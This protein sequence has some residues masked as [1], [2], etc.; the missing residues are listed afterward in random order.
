MSLPLTQACS[1]LVRERD[2]QLVA[3]P[4]TSIE[5]LLKV[6]DGALCFDELGLQDLDGVVARRAWRRHRDSEQ[7][8]QIS[9][10]ERPTARV[11]PVEAL[12]KLREQR[13][14]L[15][16]KHVGG[17]RSE[18]GGG[19]ARGSAILF[20]MAIAERAVGVALLALAVFAVIVHV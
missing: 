2:P 7:T 11:A 4:A 5:E 18:L 9:N 10:D 1:T 12:T 8:L 19:P 20:A 16:A 15:P 13:D 3:D 6:I 17:F 14:G